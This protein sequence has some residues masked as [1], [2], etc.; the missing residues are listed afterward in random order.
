M[1]NDR[2]EWVEGWPEEEGW[3]GWQQRGGITD[4]STNVL[5]MSNFG[6]GGAGGEGA[7]ERE[8]GRNGPS[9]GYL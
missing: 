9:L 6:G 8:K 1:Q 7:I 5:I 4:Y 2:N 3:G